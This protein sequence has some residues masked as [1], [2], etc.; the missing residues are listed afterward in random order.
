MKMITCQVSNES[1]ACIAFHTFYTPFGI[2]TITPPQF[3]KWW[4][5]DVN[6]G[7]CEWMFSIRRNKKNTDYMI[8]NTKHTGYINTSGIILNS[9]DVPKR[10]PLAY[11]AAWSMST[12]YNLIITSFYDTWG[13]RV[14]SPPI[15]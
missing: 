12:M 9:T 5:I 15:F 1:N 2:A 8:W 11:F 10:L 14:K 3:E 4:C 13:K 6:F 7:D